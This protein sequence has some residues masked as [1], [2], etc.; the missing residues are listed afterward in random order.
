MAKNSTL[1]L[2]TTIGSKHAT[3]PGNVQDQLAV[4]YIIK[5]PQLRNLQQTPVAKHPIITEEFAGPLRQS[6]YRVSTREREPIRQQV[7]EQLRDDIIQPS[8]S[9]WASTVVLV[10]KKEGTLRFCFDN[11][12]LNTITKKD[13][14]PVPWIDDAL[15]RLCNA[16]YFSS[17]DLNTGYWQ[18]EVDESDR[19]K[20]AFITPDGFYEFKV[21][22]FGSRSCDSVY[23]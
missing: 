16:K 14:Y 23:R 21:M 3:K 18:M 19:E 4:C 12:Q 13:I 5:Q 8:K 20:T 22:P 6:P 10:M 1:L 9:T 2:A 11:H 17:M 15:H 7:N